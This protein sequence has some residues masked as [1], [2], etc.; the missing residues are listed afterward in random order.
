MNCTYSASSASEPVYFGLGTEMEMCIANAMMYPFD[1]HIPVYC[2]HTDGFGYCNGMYGNFTA[3]PVSSFLTQDFRDKL[4]GKLVGKCDVKGLVCQEGCKEAIEEVIEENEGC[5]KGS[6]A[7]YVRQ[8][9]LRSEDIGR[10]LSNMFI[11]CKDR[12]NDSTENQQGIEQIQS[13]KCILKTGKDEINHSKEDTNEGNGGK[14]ESQTDTNGGKEGHQDLTNPKLAVT[15]K[16]S[17]LPTKPGP[18]KNATNPLWFSLLAIVGQK[19]LNV[20]E[21]VY[22]LFSVCLSFAS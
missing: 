14:I 2:Y 3:C 4:H 16:P 17:S 9:F 12:E 5:L 15:S 19:I 8:T 1:S 7:R 6:I 11:S 20:W 13:T 18:P 10:A 22:F 21:V